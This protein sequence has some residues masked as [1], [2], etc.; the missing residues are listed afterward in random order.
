MGHP[1]HCR[2]C[3]EGARLHPGAPAGVTELRYVPDPAV[4]GLLSA[5]NGCSCASLGWGS[6]VVR[7]KPGLGSLRGWSQRA[8]E[9]ASSSLQSGCL[10]Q[11]LKEGRGLLLIHLL[12]LLYPYC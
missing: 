8:A 12:I 1:G 7:E 4:L 2:D 11:L 5:V 10:C 6:G 9:A 3:G